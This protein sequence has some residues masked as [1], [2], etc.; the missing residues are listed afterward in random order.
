MDVGHTTKVGQA[1]A[2]GKFKRAL[3]CPNH[4]DLGFVIPVQQLICYFSIAGFVGQLQSCR[5]QPLEIDDG[6]KGSRDAIRKAIDKFAPIGP[7]KKLLF[8]SLENDPQLDDSN[9]PHY[10]RN[11]EADASEALDQLGLHLSRKYPEG[12]IPS[13]QSN[14]VFKESVRFFVTELEKLIQSLSPE[15][16]SEW[17]QP[18][19]THFSKRFFDHFPNAWKG[20]T[21]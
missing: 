7:K 9:I 17:I 19:D 4:F 13:E 5:T 6:D 16:G 15:K 18:P 8:L 10:R 3:N 11:Q 12:P 21:D 1:S 14:E 2:A 20:T